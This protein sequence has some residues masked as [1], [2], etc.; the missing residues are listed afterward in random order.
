MGSQEHMYFGKGGFELNT[1][2]MNL[3]II[4]LLFHVLLLFTLTIVTRAALAV[5]IALKE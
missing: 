3:I 2:F 5:L 4:G 1:P